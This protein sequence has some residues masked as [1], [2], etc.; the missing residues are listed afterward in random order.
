MLNVCAAFPVLLAK[1]NQSLKIRV[2]CEN[3]GWAIIEK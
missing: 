1:I 2:L 3:V